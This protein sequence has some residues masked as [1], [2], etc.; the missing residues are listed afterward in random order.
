MTDKDKKPNK[1]EPIQPHKKD[2]LKAPERVEK[3]HRPKQN[4]PKKPPGK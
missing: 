4:P 1:P 2:T 3:S